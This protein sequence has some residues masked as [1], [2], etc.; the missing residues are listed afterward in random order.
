LS[1]LN[2]INKLQN[3]FKINISKTL[4]ILILK[5]FIIKDAKDEQ[6]IARYLQDIILYTQLTNIEKI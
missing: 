6:K 2:F 1:F 5:I 4:N 3:Y